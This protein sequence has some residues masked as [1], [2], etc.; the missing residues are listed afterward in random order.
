MLPCDRSLLDNLLEHQ[1]FAKKSRLPSLFSDFSPLVQTNVDGYNANVNAW[2]NALASCVLEGKGHDGRSCFVIKLDRGLLEDLTSK[3]WGQPLAIASVERE[4]VQRKTWIPVDVFEQ[5]HEAIDHVAGLFERLSFTSV[6]QW[7]LSKVWSSSSSSRACAVSGRALVVIA[8]LEAVVN[9]FLPKI[10]KEIGQEYSAHI[11]TPDLLCH[12]IQEI[13]GYI[14][15]MDDMN[16]LLRYLERDRKVIVRTSNVVKFTVNQEAI[17]EVDTAIAQLKSTMTSLHHQ[18]T[19]L[20]RKTE[21]SRTAARQAVAEGQK[22][23]ALSHLR[24]QKLADAS[25]DERA[26]TYHN[27]E[28]LLSRIDDAASNVGIVNVMEGGVQALRTLIKEIGGVGRVEEIMDDVQEQQHLSD[29]ISN[30]IRVPVQTSTLDGIH[31]VEEEDVE[32]EYLD[33][34]RKD[35]EAALQ[36]QQD[37]EEA[38]RKTVPAQ[39][40]AVSEVPKEAEHGLAENASEGKQAVAAD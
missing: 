38:V 31:D 3:Q 34:L 22:T 28:Q 16:L 20:T 24:S 6:L 2:T 17:N 26:T 10:N 27:L 32:Q 1:D 19:D 36:Q 37:L 7:S 40:P 5:Q 12:R 11:T 18:I 23:L 4:A 35:E 13:S 30:A 21:A 8:N 29:E 39:A 9:A 25:L 33:M 15:S 14:L